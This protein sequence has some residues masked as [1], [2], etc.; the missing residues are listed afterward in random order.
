M[1]NAE[2]L[3]TEIAD[4]YGGVAAAFADAI[5]VSGAT[6]SR[7][8]AGKSPPRLPL[9]IVLEKVSQG[10][11]PRDGWETDEDRETVAEKLSTFRESKRKQR[12]GKAA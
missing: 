2:R 5:D 1:R 9:R 3:K 7:W 12:G 8:L 6:V 4:N 10:R 11:I